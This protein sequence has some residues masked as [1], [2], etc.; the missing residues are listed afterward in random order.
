MAPGLVFVIVL[1]TKFTEGAWIVV[2][3]APV[4]FVAM[5]AVAAALPPAGRGA[6]P[7][8]SGVSLPGQVHAVV[9]VS[10]LLA[11]T[12]R[13]LAFAQ[14][15]APATLRAVKVSAEDAE[16]PLPR[17]WEQRGVP[18]PLVVIESPY[19]ETVRPVQLYVRQLRREYPGDVDLDRHPRVRGRTL[20]A[21]RAAQPDGAEAQGAAAVRAVRDR[22]ERAVGDRRRSGEHEPTSRTSG[23]RTSSRTSSR[24]AALADDG[25]R[26]APAA[27]GPRP[28]ARSCCR[29]S[30]CCWT[31]WARPLA[32][33]RGAALPARGR[34]VALVGGV[35]VALVSAV[36]A[37]FLINYFFVRPVHTFEVGAG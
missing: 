9:L 34:L 33:E 29:C 8:A 6:A 12:L 14:A 20:V 13:A 5:K 24:L 21:E 18:V 22:H 23:R 2:V 36:V 26:A 37:T 17:E 28:G 7:T 25:A 27:R 10:N 35:V 3:A 19:R 4:L 16:D 11:P 32:R 15:T 31:A 30:R 1:V